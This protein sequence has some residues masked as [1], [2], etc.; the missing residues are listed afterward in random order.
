MSDNSTDPLHDPTLADSD[1]QVGGLAPERSGPLVGIRVLDF[2]RLAP[3]PMATAIL[4]DL[5]AEVI[6]VEEPGGGRRAREERRLRGEPEG[7]YSPAELLRRKHNPFERGKLSVALDLKDPVGRSLALRLAE[8]VDA[9]VEGFRPGVMARL[10]LAHSDFESVNPG[11]VYCSLTGYGQTGPRRDRVGHD[12]NYL[13]DTGALSLFAPFDSRRPIVPPNLLADYAG[14]SLQAVIAIVS[15][16]YARVSTGRGQ[17]IDV[18][19]SDGVLSLLGPEVAAYAATG[20]VPVGGRTRLTGSMA[21]YN[22]YETAD[23]RYL[24]LGCNEPAFFRE[25]CATLELDELIERQQDDDPVW[26]EHARVAIQAKIRQAPLSRWEQVFS[27][28]D[29]AFAPVRTLD[30]VL[31]DPHYNA[32]G[33]IHRGESGDLQSTRAGSP[34]H[35]SDTRVVP[36]FDVP[37]PGEHSTM[38]LSSIGCSSGEIAALMASGVVA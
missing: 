26:Q 14:G 31:T 9:V 32:R 28:G 24:S 23:G 15:A 30:E 3:G 27:E 33:L 19:L 22:V 2:S 37:A 21:Y 36:W 4:S 7:S 29:I 10:G 8:H 12:L 6:K 34:Y 1:S 11:V 17:S 20:R 13:A 18:S 5:G 35:F 38:L 16:L 25:L